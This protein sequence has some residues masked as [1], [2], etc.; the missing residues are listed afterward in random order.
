MD[1]ISITWAASMVTFTFS[2]SPVVWG[3][4]GL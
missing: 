2:S 4:S 3:R 1:L